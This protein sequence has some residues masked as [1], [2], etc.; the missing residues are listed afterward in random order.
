[1]VLMLS[2]PTSCTEP[3]R[4]QAFVGQAN[5]D[6]PQ[7]RFRACVEYASLSYVFDPEVGKR[8]ASCNERLEN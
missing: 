4:E 1:M 8:L 5:T 2:L 6:E 7:A 3:G